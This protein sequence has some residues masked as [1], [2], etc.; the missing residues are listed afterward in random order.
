MANIEWPKHECG[1][2][3]DHNDYKNYYESIETAVSEIEEREVGAGT[4]LKDVWY[5]AAE[6]QKILDTGE[7]WELQWYPDTPV[8]FYV[9][10][11]SSFETLIK[12][13]KE[14]G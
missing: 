9:V 1:M 11:A 2:C 6:R 7:L 4:K 13:A 12:Y 14:V 3:L 5:S 8:G 10:R